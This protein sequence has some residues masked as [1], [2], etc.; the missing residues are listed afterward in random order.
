MVLAYLNP[1]GRN[2]TICGTFKPWTE[3]RKKK[4]GKN[5][6]CGQCKPCSN[7]NLDVWRAKTRDRRLAYNRTY[8]A[9]ERGRKLMLDYQARKPAKK[10]AQTAVMRAIRLGELVRPDCCE[11]CE[12]QRK[13]EGHH[14][15]YAKP[16]SVRWLC[17]NCH[18]AWHRKHGEAANADMP[19]PRRGPSFVSMKERKA[20]RIQLIPAMIAGGMHKRDIASALCV[21]LFTVYDDI[22][23]I[24]R[25]L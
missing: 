3:F 19:V 9:S 23:R 14:D 6:R 7:A 21:S 12:Q 18:K 1:D 4:R 25:G 22:K 13:V 17:R 5:G 8:Y 20:A 16:L 15:D 2:C 11:S 10:A 24:E